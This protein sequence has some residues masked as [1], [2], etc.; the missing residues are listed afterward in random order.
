[1]VSVVYQNCVYSSN[2]SWIG[3]VFGAVGLVN[4]GLIRMCVYL[5]LQYTT[6]EWL[7]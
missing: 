7:E 5:A 6:L 3:Y 4:V 1:M 2:N